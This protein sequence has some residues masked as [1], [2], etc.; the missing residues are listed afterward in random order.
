MQ[1]KAS[2]ASPI[3]VVAAAA[4]VLNAEVAE[5][6]PSEALVSALAIS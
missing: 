4:A 1:K 6:I 5:G 3:A 2:G